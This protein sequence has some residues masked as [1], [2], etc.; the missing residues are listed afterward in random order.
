MAGVDAG[1]GELPLAVPVPELGGGYRSYSILGKG[2][3]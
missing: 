2:V 3:P 1:M